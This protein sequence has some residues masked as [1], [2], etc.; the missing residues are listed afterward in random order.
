MAAIEA[1]ATPLGV[2]VI[3]EPVRATAD[4]EPALANFA[5]VPNAG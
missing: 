4:I 5:R 2:Q 3:T 1:A